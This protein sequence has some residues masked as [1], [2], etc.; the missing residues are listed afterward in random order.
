MTVLDIFQYSLIG[1][2]AL[3]G[4]GGIIYVVLKEEE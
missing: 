2:V 4:V 1:I 3:V